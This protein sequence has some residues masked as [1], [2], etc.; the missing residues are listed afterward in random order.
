[1]KIAKHCECTKG[2]G[3]YETQYGP[4]DKEVIPMVRSTENTAFDKHEKHR[5]HAGSL[6]IDLIF[7][8]QE[9]DAARS[10]RKAESG[11]QQVQYQKAT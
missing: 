11:S 7:A 3:G 6:E 9:Y 2:E 8:K 5:E 10:S 1:M 4:R